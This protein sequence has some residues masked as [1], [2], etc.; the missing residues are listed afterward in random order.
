MVEA[1]NLKFFKMSLV[2]GMQKSFQL[3][4]YEKMF[5]IVSDFPPKN[6]YTVFKYTN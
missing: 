3:Y 2:T 4:L 5:I 6:T 1:Q